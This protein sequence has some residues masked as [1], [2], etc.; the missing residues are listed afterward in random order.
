MNQTG[1]TVEVGASASAN[2]ILFVSSLGSYNLASDSAGVTVWGEAHTYGTFNHAGGRQQVS[3]NVNILG[4]KG[5]YLLSGGTLSSPVLNI[6]SGGNF[7]WSGGSLT[8]ESL[9]LAGRMSLTGCGRTLVATTLNIDEATGKLDLADNSM[10]IDYPGDSLDAYVQELRQDLLTGA[11]FSSVSTG[12]K[13]LGYIDNSVAERPSFAGHTFPVGDYTQLLVTYTYEGDTNLDGI[14]DMAD[15]S[16]LA[17]HWQSASDWLGG[18]FDY[19]GTVEVNDL[20][21]LATKLVG[22]S[23]Q[24]I[25]S[26]VACG[27]ARHLWF[28]QR[29]RARTDTS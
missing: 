2:G 23:G 14:V 27:S 21:L 15:L 10:I 24:H 20:G 8:I 1:G 3:G 12:G 18:D 25:G 5:T 17:T 29:C 4:P 28:A 9:T 16:A 19:N 13:R 11:L 26:A 22:G 7:T 6:A